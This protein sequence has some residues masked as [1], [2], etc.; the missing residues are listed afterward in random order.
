MT[1]IETFISHL[2]A[3]RNAAIAKFPT[4]KFQLPALMEEVGEL[5]NALMECQVGDAHRFGTMARNNAIIN[6]YDEAVQV[7]SCALRIATEGD[8]RK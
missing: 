6:I 2:L 4:N 1:K 8:E 3:E 5:A 7:A